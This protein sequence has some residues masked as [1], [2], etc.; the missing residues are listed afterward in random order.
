MSIFNC[1]IIYPIIYHA[2]LFQEKR[3]KESILDLTK[4]MDKS[5]RVKFSGG[6][7]GKAELDSYSISNGTCLIEKTNGHIFSFI[8]LAKGEGGP[9]AQILVFKGPSHKMILKLNHKNH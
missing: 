3:K 5:I 4:Y 2:L 1:K 6:R 9:S 7:E 8:N